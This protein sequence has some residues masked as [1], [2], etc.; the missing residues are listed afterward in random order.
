MKLEVDH[1]MPKFS[2]G[3]DH[4]GN[5]VTAC[6]DC[7][8]GKF[9]EV[10]PGFTP[11]W[12]RRNGRALIGPPSLGAIGDA[13]WAAF[14]KPTELERLEDSFTWADEEQRNHPAWGPCE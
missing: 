9:T 7:N 4:D 13:W 5:L 14:S 10:V 6:H 1:I 11:F 8:I 12:M 2:G 3:N